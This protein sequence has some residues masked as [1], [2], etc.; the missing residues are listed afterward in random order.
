LGDAAGQFVTHHNHPGGD[1]CYT[2][3]EIVGATVDGGFGGAVGAGLGIVGVATSQ[4]SL[5][6]VNSF[7][8]GQP[9][10]AGGVIGWSVGESRTAGRKDA[11]SGSL[12]IKNTRICSGPNRS[13]DWLK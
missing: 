4:E 8:S 5:A 6:L 11:D 1:G 7:L 10:Y 9:G 2:V 13:G 12:I 3:D